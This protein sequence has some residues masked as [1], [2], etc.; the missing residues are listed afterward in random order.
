MEEAPPL[1]F[2][3]PKDSEEITET[4]KVIDNKENYTL[5]FIIKGDSLTINIYE[6]YDILNPYYTINLTLQEIKALDKAFYALT[7]CKEFLN[8]IKALIENKQLSIKKNEK[9]LCL[10]FIVEYLFQ[11][12]N[13]EIV[14]LPGKMNLENSFKEICKELSMLK[15]KVL[16]NEQ[17]Y[18][19]ILNKQNEEI[20]NLKEEN[21]KLN[22]KL[23][24]L[25]LIINRINDKNIN[26]ND[27][28]DSVII[29]GN[30][31]LDLIKQGIKGRMKRDI[32][33]FKKLYQASVDGG[34]PEIFHKKCDNIPNTLILIKSI[35]NRRFGGFTSLTWQLPSNRY[36]SK[37]DKNS[38]LF[39]LDKHK[40]YSIKNLDN[41]ICCWN[42]RGPSF[43]SAHDISI[44]GNPIKEKKLYTKESLDRC[45]YDYN[46]D[47]NALSEDGKGN[48]IFAIDYE[49]FQ[50]IFN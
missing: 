41:N 24:E 13:I 23:E 37:L 50:I 11:K 22:K 36:I 21:K 2:E 1:Y 34:D 38:F 14:L 45:S 15:K 39:S 5:N 18:N 20:I 44:E 8:Y 3:T 10:N 4:L 42:D 7:S 43:G 28:I 32:K 6:N 9:N 16:D 48:K 47:K 29:E 40:I 26:H 33:Q 25:V 30:D 46:G 35:G 27:S 31:D 19:E 17:N 49:V 12:H